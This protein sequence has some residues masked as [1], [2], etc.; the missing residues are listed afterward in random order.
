M[1]RQK[2]LAF[3]GIAEEHETN[4]GMALESL[5]CARDSDLGAEIATHDI[6]GNSDHACLALI[7]VFQG[8]RAAA[9]ESG[10]NTAFRRGHN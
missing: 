6:D 4:V 8:Q 9:T 1:L 3:G 2:R 5:G 10:Q 7:L